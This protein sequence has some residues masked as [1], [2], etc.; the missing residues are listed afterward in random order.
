MTNTYAPVAARSHV[1]LEPKVAGR[2]YST[3]KRTAEGK[4]L[5]L[6]RRAARFVKYGA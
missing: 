1:A 5:T 2:R 6:A 3:H 4:A